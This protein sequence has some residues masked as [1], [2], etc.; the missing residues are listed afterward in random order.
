[1]MMT[2]ML[3]WSQYWESSLQRTVWWRKR[4]AREEQKTAQP[5]RKTVVLV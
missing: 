3:T 2:L 4:L 1:M 5:S